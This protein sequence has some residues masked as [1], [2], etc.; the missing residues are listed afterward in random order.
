VVP[1]VIAS[2]AVIFFGIFPDPLYDFASRAG[3]AIT[4]LTG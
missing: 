2:V 3:D 4:S 1:I